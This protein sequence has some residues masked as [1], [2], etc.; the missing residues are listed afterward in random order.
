MTIADTNKKFK[1]NS[2]YEFSLV[3]CN[4]SKGISFSLN[5]IVDTIIYMNGKND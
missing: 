4:G 3:P 2:E 1:I 5:K